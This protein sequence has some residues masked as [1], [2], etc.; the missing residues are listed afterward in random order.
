MPT[1]CQSGS[2]PH[3]EEYSCFGCHYTQPKA[4]NTIT[5]TNGESNP[6][7]GAV[8]NEDKE[9]K[10]IQVCEGFAKNLWGNEDLNKPT[11]KFD[12]CGFFYDDTVVIP[13]T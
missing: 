5:I 11:T 9:I 3:L 8:E 13:S 6:L 1:G 7:T 2:M 12:G 4:V 10:V